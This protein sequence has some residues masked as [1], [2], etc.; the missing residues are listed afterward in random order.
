[1][2]SQDTK[3]YVDDGWR[4]YIKCSRCGQIA[5][6]RSNGLVRKHYKG[7]MREPSNV[8]PMSGDLATNHEVA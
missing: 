8:C 6:V 7:P 1:M 5:G 2:K 4:R 3:K